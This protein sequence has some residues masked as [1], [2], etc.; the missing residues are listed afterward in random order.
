LNVIAHPCRGYSS[1][2]ETVGEVVEDQ[3]A[4]GMTGSWIGTSR[5]EA[6]AVRQGSQL[7]GPVKRTILSR[8]TVPLFPFAYTA[9]LPVPRRGFSV[10]GLAVRDCKTEDAHAHSRKHS[11]T[12]RSHA[13]RDQLQAV[14]RGVAPKLFSPRD[15][16][17]E[18][19][20]SYS[21]DSLGKICLRRFQRHAVARTGPG[22]RIPRRCSGRSLK[23]IATL[24]DRLP[25]QVA[26][27]A[28]SLTH[29]VSHGPVET[30]LALIRVNRPVESKSSSNIAS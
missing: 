24:P 20:R 25:R 7:G 13:C 19:A 30:S 10:G 27:P 2:N 12:Q 14:T 16:W 21:H 3:A 5:D 9:A 11:P 6:N 18:E 23:A 8:S 26:S 22:L 1:T 29:A 4:A 17:Y 28:Q 15:R